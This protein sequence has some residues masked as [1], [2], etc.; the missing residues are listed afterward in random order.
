[1]HKSRLCSRIE[2]CRQWLPSTLTTPTQFS[3]VLSLSKLMSDLRKPSTLP[4]NCVCVHVC[5]CV[6][7]RMC[8]CVCAC[9]IA[10]KDILCEYVSAH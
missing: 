1:M 7:V 5:V 4:M 3:G 9:M 2:C 6:R 8:I 10:C